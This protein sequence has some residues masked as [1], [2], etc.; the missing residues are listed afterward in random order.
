METNLLSCDTQLLMRTLASDGCTTILMFN[1]YI[2]GYSEASTSFLCY[3]RGRCY[4]IPF[5]YDY[6][7]SFDSPSYLLSLMPANPHIAAVHA[8]LIYFNDVDVTETPIK[9]TMCYHVFEESWAY[10][11]FTV[12]HLCKTTTTGVYDILMHTFGDFPFEAH[13]KVSNMLRV[14]PTKESMDKWLVRHATGVLE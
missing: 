10:S 14:F 8:T 11:D 5:R 9:V 12:V 2:I 13:E 7:Y 1:D 6:P 3:T 4:N